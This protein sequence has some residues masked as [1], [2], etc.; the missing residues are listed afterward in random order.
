M[1][2]SLTQRLARTTS[3][4]VLASAMS[5]ASAQE[6]PP[7]SCATYAL[8]EEVGPAS[9]DGSSPSVAVGDT[10]TFTMTPGT[11]TTA[12]WRIVNDSSGTPGSTLT[13]GGTVSNTLTYTVTVASASAP[14]GFFVDS[15]DGTGTITAS[16]RSGA[17]STNAVP[18]LS[19]WGLL[20]TS[21]V[22]ALGTFVALR[23]RKASGARA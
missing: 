5:L 21:A 16:C 18:T 20:L 19:E 11:A 2:I 12:A 7:L 8:N 1:R 10:F 13:P 9:T 17:L 23:R 3:F 4:L 6:G 14:V 15:I 22:V